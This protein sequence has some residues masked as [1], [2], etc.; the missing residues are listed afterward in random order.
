M[1]HQISV[2]HDGRLVLLRVTG[3]VTL[4]AITAF[5]QELLEPPFVELTY[6]VLID[7]REGDFRELTSDHIYS[8]V[9]YLGRAADILPEIRHA[10]IV[11][12]Q[13]QYGMVRMFQLLAD[14]NP[15]LTCRVFYD[16][17]EARRWLAGEPGEIL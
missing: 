6:D 17:A 2:D 1:T 5:I 10:I 3:D 13:L 7:F 14:D 8:L 9:D 4:S 12:Q 16:E 11:G 15:G